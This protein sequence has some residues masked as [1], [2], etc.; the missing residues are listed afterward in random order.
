MDGISLINTGLAAAALTA[1]SRLLEAL[2]KKS[3]LFKGRVEDHTL[4][5]RVRAIESRLNEMSDK[6]VREDFPYRI[7]QLEVNAR[8]RGWD[9]S[10]PITGGGND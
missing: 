2:I 8:R 6:N 10:D 4:V 1:A 9:L 7:T 5:N 3:S